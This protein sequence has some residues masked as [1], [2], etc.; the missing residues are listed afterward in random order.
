MSRNSEPVHPE[1]DS[2]AV[3]LLPPCGRGLGQ[4]KAVIEIDPAGVLFL[5]CLLCN[6]IAPVPYRRSGNDA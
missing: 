1:L 5:R 3:L 6:C 2:P 4:C